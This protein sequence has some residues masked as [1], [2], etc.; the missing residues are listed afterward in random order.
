MARPALP[1]GLHRPADTDGID[2]TEDNAGAILTPTTIERARATGLDAHA[3]LK[4][5]DAYGFFGRL[6]DL[7]T[8]DPTLTN[9][10]DFK[11]VLIELSQRL[12]SEDADV[13]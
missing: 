2:G 7:V 12:R 6:G 13:G 9:V 4:N 10:N 8:T 5:N 3:H 1:A 11:S